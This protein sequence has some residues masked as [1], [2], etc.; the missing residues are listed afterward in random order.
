MK[1]GQTIHKILVG[2]ASLLLMASLGAGI[3]VNSNA[4]AS[5][6]ETPYVTKLG[7]SY[8]HHRSHYKKYSHRKRSARRHASKRRQRG[9]RSKNLRRHKKHA[10]KIRAKKGFLNSRFQTSNSYRRLVKSGYFDARP[11]GGNYI[12]NKYAPNDKRAVVPSHYRNFN[13]YQLGWCKGKFGQ[14]NLTGYAYNNKARGWFVAF[15]NTGAN[16]TNNT[17]NI[18]NS[19]N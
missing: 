19:N 18:N 5:S 7:K 1:K 13:I 2:S 11:I 8:K 6:V 15:H 4:S 16:N 3:G 9:H 14:K 12:F 17:N 10:N